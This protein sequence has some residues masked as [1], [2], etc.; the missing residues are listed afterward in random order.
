MD[1]LFSSTDSIDQ[2]E[3]RQYYTASEAAAVKEGSLRLFWW[4]GKRWKVCSKSSVDKA[5]DFVW[6]T[7]DYRSKPKNTD[8]SGTMFAVGTPKGGGFAWW[9]IPLIIV[10]VI[11]VVVVVRLFWVLAVNRRG[12]TID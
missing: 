10:I 12:S 2:V 1:V 7:L 4:N 8:L 11:L 3:I 5:N 6:A 9:L